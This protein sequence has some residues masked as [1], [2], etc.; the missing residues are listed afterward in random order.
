MV[1]PTFNFR[2]YSKRHVFHFVTKD[3]AQNFFK[4]AR[5]TPNQNFLTEK[6]QNSTRWSNL[7]VFQQS[8]EDVTAKVKVQIDAQHPLEITLNS[9][10]GALRVSYFTCIT[11]RF[12]I[13]Q[14]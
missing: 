8:K 1:Q 7:K 12:G 4:L 5:K 6:Y 10:S 14:E 9:R 2:L 13:I 3:T 11:N